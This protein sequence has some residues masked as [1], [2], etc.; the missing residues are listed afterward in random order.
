MASEP[1][2]FVVASAGTHIAL[3]ITAMNDK[4]LSYKAMGL[5]AY[6]RTRPTREITHMP[7]LMLATRD[8]DHAVRTGVKELLDADYLHLVQVRDKL[9]RIKQVVYVSFPKPV[10]IEAEALADM[11]VKGRV[12]LP[13]SDYPHVGNHDVVRTG[14][15][16]SDEHNTFGI[17]SRDS[18]VYNTIPPIGDIDYKQ[19]SV[20]ATTQ[21]QNPQIEKLLLL[22]NSLQTLPTHKK[23]NQYKT[24]RLIVQRLTTALQNHSPMVLTQAM[25]NYNWFLQQPYTIVRHRQEPMV[26][27]LPEFFEFSIYHQAMIDKERHPLRGLDSWFLECK[28]GKDHL[29]DAYSLVRKDPN[30]KHTE[31][32]IKALR[33]CHAFVL[34][35]NIPAPDM[36]SLIRASGYLV[37]WI[38]KRKDRL[39]KRNIV[40]TCIRRLLAMLTRGTKTL[41]LGYLVSDITWNGFETYMIEMGEMIAGKANVRRED[42]GISQAA[43]KSGARK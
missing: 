20:A 43:G 5:H 11:V 38:D 4:T 40:G 7:D 22:W 8:G 35:T 14:H 6:I 1:K 24:Y 19:H 30:P 21:S 36:N 12:T 34:P 10:N 32:L 27:G 37:A 39:D 28:K 2:L 18:V 31:A 23:G 16:L 15:G 17:I 13:L 9:G 42:H 29:L 3:D 26:V 41:H 33:E 25:E